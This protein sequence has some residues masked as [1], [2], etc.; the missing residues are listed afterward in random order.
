MKQ[1]V[2]ITGKAHSL[3]KEELEKDGYEV[4]YRPDIQYAELE[5]RIGEVTGLVIT[6]RIRVDQVLLEKAHQLKWIGRLGSGMELVDVP[7]AESKGIRCISSPE[8]NR[9]AVA[10]QALAMLLNMMNN[11]SIAQQQVKE[12][13][14]LRDENRGWEL[15]GRTVGLI[16]YGNTAMAFARLLA[17]FNVTILAY[18][19]YKFGFAEGHV[20]EASQEQIA[21][22]ADIVSFHIPLT[23]ETRHLANESFFA[24]LQ[25]RPYILNTSRGKVIDT[26]GLIQALKKDQIRGA[27]LDVLENEKLDTYQEEERKRLDWLLAQPNVLITPHIAGYSHEAYQRMSEVVLKKLRDPGAVFGF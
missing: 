15:S 7:F 23:A 6:T 9:N 8:G 22:Y 5:S 12:G 20:H 26:D 18:D 27:A 21:R 14:W 13:K 19:K 3:L 25:Q 11:I 24:S 16:G 1:L 2:I 4:E 17:P 10:E